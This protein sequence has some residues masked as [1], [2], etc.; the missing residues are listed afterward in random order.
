MPMMSLIASVTITAP[1]EAQSTPSTPPSAQL[2][3]M[4]GGGGSG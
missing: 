1:I 3:T 4:P 2:G